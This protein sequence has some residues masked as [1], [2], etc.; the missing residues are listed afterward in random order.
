M[1]ILDVMF[2]LLVLV[3]LA[4]GFFQGTIKLLIA[5]I[6]FYIS[7]ILASLYF[8]LV[9]QFF[10]TQFNT[11]LEIGQ[12]VAFVLIL[13][14]GFLFLTVAGLYTF[15]YL[16]FPPSLD[17]IDRVLGTL[18]GLVLGALIL[19]IMASML[20]ALFV[21]RNPSAI[22]TFPIMRAFQGAVRESFLVQFFSNNILPLI[23]YSVRPVLP[24]AADII[25]QVQ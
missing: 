2:I 6:G 1:N 18:L 20:E 19:G 16:R 10:R 13:A 12:I 15:R 21:F 24:P 11:T 7:I 3:G 8:Q 9:G 23:Y 17:F 5:I 4:I 14:I 22:L 25:F